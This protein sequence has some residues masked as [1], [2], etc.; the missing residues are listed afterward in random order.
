MKS[1]RLSR[2]GA[3]FKTVLLILVRLHVEDLRQDVAKYAEH[4]VRVPAILRAAIVAV[5]VT[6]TE[7]FAEIVVV[8]GQINVVAIV[9]VGRILIT[10]RV[11][12]AE[13]ITILSVCLSG[14]HAF[15]IALP[16]GLP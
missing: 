3:S 13:T 9:A 10:D 15:L 14:A 12:R 8:L 2:P 7:T 16:Y 1:A 11:L 4:T 5:F 6:A